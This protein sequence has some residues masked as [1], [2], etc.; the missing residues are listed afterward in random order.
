MSYNF[1]RTTPPSKPEKR[2]RGRP[3]GSGLVKYDPIYAN[4]AEKI[5]SRLGATD[6]DLAFTF[7]VSEVAINLWK[8]EHREFALA[9]KQKI[10]ADAEVA[11][12][13]YRSAIG[14]SHDA[15]K[16]LVVAGQVAE[17]HYVEHYPPNPTSAIFWLKNRQPALWRDI[18]RKPIDEFDP[19]NMTD[20]QLNA[21][22]QRAVD[23]GTLS[24]PD[25]RG[26]DVVVDG[27]SEVVEE[28]E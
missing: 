14:Y 6:A 8:R 27:G 18:H 10:V 5:V 13:L 4:L 23:R 26:G 20:A 15:V 22:L 1:R 11:H 16:H 9:L 24:I 25:L 21:V 17:I 28:D 7:G 3:K 19:D 12:S 2:G